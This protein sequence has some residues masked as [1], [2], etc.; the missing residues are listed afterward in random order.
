MSYKIIKLVHMG[1]VLNCENVFIQRLYHVE[2]KFLLT[3]L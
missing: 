2:I 1:C 3:G